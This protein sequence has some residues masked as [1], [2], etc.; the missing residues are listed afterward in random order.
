MKILIACCLLMLHAHAH[1]WSVQN[2]QHILSLIDNICGDSWCA[3]NSDYAFREF[4][5]DFSAQTCSLVFDVIP[6]GT[7]CGKKRRHRVEKQCSIENIKSSNDLFQEPS[8]LNRAFYGRLS[9]CINR[10]SEEAYQGL[11]RPC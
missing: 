7:S 9:D 2:E 4:K 5:C 3:S 1:S 11:E 10:V 8:T 6:W